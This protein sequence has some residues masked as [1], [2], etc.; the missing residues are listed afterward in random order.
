MVAK[1][2][3]LLDKPFMCARRLGWRSFAIQHVAD[4]AR[5]AFTAVLH[6]ETLGPPAQ[7]SR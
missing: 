3:E 5:S 6:G 2:R 7:C 1:S 4:S